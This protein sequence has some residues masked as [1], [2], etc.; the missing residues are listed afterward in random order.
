MWPEKNNIRSS[1]YKLRY[2]ESLIN[3]E[4]EK[5]REKRFRFNLLESDSNFESEQNFRFPLQ[6][7]MFKIIC[8][9]S[10]FHEIFTT[11]ISI[12][13]FVYCEGRCFS[14]YAFLQRVLTSFIKSVQ[15]FKCQDIWRSIFYCMILQIHLSWIHASKFFH[16]KEHFKSHCCIFKHIV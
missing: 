7:K 5:R 3:W 6:Y 8:I 11:S 2:I 12:D 9:Y 10:R 15:H 13:R 4:M 14:V 1:Y 16:W